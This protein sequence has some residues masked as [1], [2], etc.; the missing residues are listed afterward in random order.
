MTEPHTSE[1]IRLLDRTPKSMKRDRRRAVELHRGLSELDVTALM[2]TVVTHCGSTVAK[3]VPLERMERA[4]GV[5]LGLSPVADA[6]GATGII[7]SHQSLARPDGDLRVVPDLSQVRVLAPGW[8]WAPGNRYEQDGSAYAADQR[9]F[10]LRLAAELDGRGVTQKGAFE[11]EWVVGAP[12]PD[13]AFVPGMTGGPYSAQRVL[14]DPTYATDVMTALARAGIDVEQFHSEYAEGQFEVALPATDLVRAADDAVLARLVIADVTRRHG[15]RAS[16][17]PAVVAGLVGNG[18]HLHLSVEVDGEPVFGGGAGPGGLTEPG[19]AV[20]G[21]LL[22]SMPALMAL[23]C[24]LAASYVRV[25]PSRWAG[26][27]QVWGIENREAAVRLVPGGRDPR[28]ANVEVKPPDLAANPYL[29]VGGVMAVIGD[30]LARGVA[31][32]EPVVGDPAG[33]GHERLPTSLWEATEAFR[34][35][36]VLSSAMGEMLHRTV[37]ENREAEIRRTHGWTPQDV[38]ASTRWWQ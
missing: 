10:A 28:S 13:N 20:V 1:A 9:L 16:F 37:A 31:L 22:E 27:F 32:P 11:L 5:G 15:M 8:A 2:T 34:A 38:V 36:E 17:S 26:A 19:A 29:L 24:P 14:Q 3:V 6:F 4:A 33:G 7:D 21:G 18:G 25:G 30:A 35:N 23:G 12:A